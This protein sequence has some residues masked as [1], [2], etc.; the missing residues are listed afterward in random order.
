M[1]HYM[2]ILIFGNIPHIR[3]L[4]YPFVLVQLLPPKEIPQIDSIDETR[5]VQLLDTFLIPCQPKQSGNRPDFVT[6]LV[7]YRRLSKQ[8]IHGS[9]LRRKLP[10]TDLFASHLSDRTVLV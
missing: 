5:L 3:K 6:A 7:S 10:M 8:C 1:P 4:G 2:I 9:F